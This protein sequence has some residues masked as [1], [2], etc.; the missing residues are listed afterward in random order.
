[1]Y[2]DLIEFSVDGV[3]WTPESVDRGLATSEP[4]AGLLP[5][6][7]ANNGRFFLMGT[8]APQTGSSGI[9]V[10]AS[11][12]RDE[13][14]WSDDGKAWTRTSGSYS[15]CADFIDFGRDGL[16][17]HT[18]I[19]AAP[20]GTGL[21]LS[22]DGGKAWKPYDRDGP[23]GPVVCQGACGFGPDG[24]I[25]SN[26]TVFV[27]IKNGGKQAWLSYDGN[28]WSPIPWSGGD[29]GTSE[30]AYGGFGGFVVL[31]R[32]VLLADAYSAAK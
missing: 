27:A 9:V 13:M 28:A 15:L 20:G 21:A 23:L 11:E 10:A 25:G 2:S 19:P 6:V 12:I 5:H 1:M 31:P 32:G 8:A 24:L 18:N 26:G 22:T 4:G 17:L 29:P 7:Q 16:L 14:W 3:H 30:A